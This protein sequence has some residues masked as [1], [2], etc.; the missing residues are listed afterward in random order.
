MEHLVPCQPAQLHDI[1]SS[2]GIKAVLQL[3]SGQ[4]QV[5]LVWSGLGQNPISL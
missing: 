4:P 5:K 1:E 3:C 2:A